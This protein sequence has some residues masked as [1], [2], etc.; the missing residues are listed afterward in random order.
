MPRISPREIPRASA[1]APATQTF[2]R[3]RMGLWISAC[4]TEP[5]IEEKGRLFVVTHWFQINEP[6]SIDDHHAPRM[7]QEAASRAV[8]TWSNC[9]NESEY[10]ARAY[11]LC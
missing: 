6:R 7:L 1:E 8:T 2:G 4:A 11:G 9:L 5:G 3:I 10:V